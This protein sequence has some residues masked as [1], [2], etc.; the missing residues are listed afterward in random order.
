MKS[1]QFKLI[2]VFQETHGFETTQPLIPGEFG[3]RKPCERLS[4]LSAYPV[5]A[6]PRGICLALS[7][8][9]AL[10]LLSA[11]PQQI[12]PHRTLLGHFGESPEWALLDSVDAVLQYART[13][14]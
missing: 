9:G 8:H 13:M 11:V 10:G 12:Q 5:H 4:I 2:C 14:T 1:D 6:A 3:A 7:S